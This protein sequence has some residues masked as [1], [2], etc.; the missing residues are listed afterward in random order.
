MPELVSADTGAREYTIYRAEVSW[1][2]VC[3]YYAAH[4]APEW[5]WYGRRY[6]KVEKGCM[7]GRL[8]MSPCAEAWWYMI[9]VDEHIEVLARGGWAPASVFKATRYFLILDE[10]EAPL[11]EPLA[12]VP[13]FGGI[14][15]HVGGSADDGQGI[16]AG[17]YVAG[18]FRASRASL[19]LP[20]MTGAEASEFLGIT[21]GLL[22]IYRFRHLYSSAVLVV[23]SQYAIKHVFQSVGPGDRPHQDVLPA[24]VLARRIVCVLEDLNIRVSAVTAS[25]REN[26]APELAQMEMEYRR[27][28]GWLPDEDRWPCDAAFKT[29]FQCVARNCSYPMLDLPPF[30]FSEG[31]LRAFA[32]LVEG[33]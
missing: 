22:E 6:L 19:A 23:D 21:L 9:P 7:Y 4:T 32:S 29:V 24:I 20:G 18:E 5:G 10:D 30:Y 3:S 11:L 1:E 12:V 31:V 28:G 15:V 33:A 16:A 27:A 25:S 26:L 2:D 8:V 17:C 14:E 13:P